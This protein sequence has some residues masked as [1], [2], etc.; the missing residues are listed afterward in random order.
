MTRGKKIK[1]K[2]NN[3]RRHSVVQRKNG[4][5]KKIRRMSKCP[6]VPGNFESS[7]E[8]V[9]QLLEEAIQPVTNR[10]LTS[11]STGFV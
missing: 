11:R 7:K 2:E 8:V 9:C 4:R 6:V 10:S 5:R 1:A 3:R